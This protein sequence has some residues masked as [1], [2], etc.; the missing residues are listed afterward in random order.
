MSPELDGRERRQHKR[1][2]TP[3]GT[4]VILSPGSD[5]ECTV[6]AIDISQGGMAFI[7]DGPKEHLDTS[8]VLK[9]L[10]QNMDLED[11]PYETVSNEQDSRY[12][13][14]SA[15]SRRLGVK[16]K[17]MGVIKASDLGAFIQDCCI[18]KKLGDLLL[19]SNLLTEAQLDQAIAEH[20]RAG[21][22][23][24]QYIVHKAMVTENQIVDLLSRQLKIDRYHPEEY[25]LDK[26]LAR[27]V[28]FKMATGLR[29]APL[30]KKGRLLTIAMTDPL[31]IMALDEAESATKCEVD[32]VIC[33]KQELADLIEDLYGKIPED[34]GV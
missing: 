5:K 11:I 28:P 23:L 3:K 20:K 13:G 9:I 26:N 1:F 22:K 17:W 25:P 10:A 31:D 6:Q 8:G 33:T 2:M 12:R 19:E 24:G 4:I 27:L 18:K 34:D 32:P 21:M 30:R 29:V 7:Y 14:S 15:S 16:F